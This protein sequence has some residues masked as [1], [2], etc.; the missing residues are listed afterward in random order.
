MTTHPWSCLLD[1]FA[2]ALDIPS[3]LI[4]KAI[5]HDG[6]AIIWPDLPEP[7][8]RQAFHIQ[9]MIDV[10]LENGWVVVPIEAMPA[11]RPNATA[12]VFRIRGMKE[13]VSRLRYYMQSS[14]GVLTGTTLEGKRHALCWSHNDVIDPAGRITHLNDFN[15]ET[16]WYMLNIKK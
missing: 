15:I 6:G 12:M 1:A 10:A 11:C 2:L 13:S 4:E 7:L 9:E 3:M 8:C 5:G 16:F 14:I